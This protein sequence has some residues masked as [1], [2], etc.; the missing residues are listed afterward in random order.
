MSDLAPE[1]EAEKGEPP[2]LAKAL[3]ILRE[4][5][6][7][8]LATATPDGQPWPSPVFFNYDTTY[9]LV[10]E[11]GRDAWHSQLIRQNPR[12]GIVVADLS[13]ETSD[14]AVFL[15]CEAE[16]VPP[17]GLAAALDTFL[18]GPHKPTA[19]T[20]HK[21]ENYLDDEPLRLFLA[22]PLR[23]YVMVV[24]HDEQGRRIDSREPIDLPGAASGT[25]T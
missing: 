20:E 1:Q 12:V 6:F 4:Q 17:E 5:R 25:S 11:T 10:W 18:H 2:S 14:E 15:D 21:V 7:C 9:R 24:T 8:V 23:A 19:A 16:E 13:G 22:I 3:R